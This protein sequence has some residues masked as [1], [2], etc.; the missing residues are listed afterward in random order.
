M[1][2][3]PG[4]TPLAEWQTSRVLLAPKWRLCYPALVCMFGTLSPDSYLLG[5]QPNLL[6]TLPPFYFFF[7]TAS[8]SF[9]FNTSSHSFL[10]N[11]TA[12]HSFLSTTGE[13]RATSCFPLSANSFILLTNV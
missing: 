5:I 11:N 2:S 8:H 9:L 6:D 12:S 4:D 3:E 1:P 13:K 7:N 10:V